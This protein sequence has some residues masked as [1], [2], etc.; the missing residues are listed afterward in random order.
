MNEKQIK[1][2][3]VDITTEMYRAGMVTASGGNISVRS[4]D[5]VKAAWIT[6][7]AIFKG[8]LN[9]DDLVLI[10]MDG[11]KLAGKYKPS[12]ES[13]YHGQVMKYRQDV[14]AVVH[15][16]APMSTIFA[17]C[18]LEMSV[19]CIEALILPAMPK[20]PWY[21]PGSQELADAVVDHLGKTIAPGAFLENHGLITVGSDLRKAANGTL[22]VEH[23]LG[24]LMQMKTAGL[25][26]AV[27]D[28]RT[29]EL[30]T[31]H[32]DKAV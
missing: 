4:I 2:Q 11:K 14:N 1:Q 21:M 23:S 30:L 32:M 25:K 15:T 7:S 17:S 24:M 20:I 28:A 13:I 31:R 12:V 5:H 19:F 18:D 6:P 29:I 26:P 3:L 27:Y 22:D 8:A 10:D 9:V 16:H